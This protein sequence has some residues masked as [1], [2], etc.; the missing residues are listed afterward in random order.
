MLKLHVLPHKFF[1]G[2]LWRSLNCLLFLGLLRLLDWWRNVWS[3]WA[4]SILE[5]RS[6]LLLLLLRARQSEIRVIPPSGI[7]S[8]P[9]EVIIVLLW[10]IM[11]LR[12]R[13]SIVNVCSIS[14]KLLNCS[15]LL[16][17]RAKVCMVVSRGAQTTN[18]CDR[19]RF[20]I[21]GQLGLPS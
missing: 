4:S 19:Y 6:K 16:H 2:R 20:L 10:L 14:F 18:P 5:G 7:V 17:G 1:K 3:A 21:Q 15:R 9:G 13:R 11:L 8:V 12:L